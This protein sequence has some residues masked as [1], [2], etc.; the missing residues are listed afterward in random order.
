[1]TNCACGSQSESG[2]SGA[3]R[4]E[5]ED[6]I[7]KVWRNSTWNQFGDGLSS[8]LGTDEDD[9]AN[10]KGRLSELLGDLGY[11]WDPPITDFDPPAPE[12]TPWA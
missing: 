10:L 8:R 2:G 5:E 1:M 6:P 12:D 7:F 4:P 3:G 9:I 11:G